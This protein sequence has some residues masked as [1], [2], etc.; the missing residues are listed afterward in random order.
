MTNATKAAIILL[1]NATM[2][3]VI[4][5]GINLTDTQQASI[6]TF[7]NAVLGVWMLATYKNSNKRIPEN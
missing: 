1:I 7:A 3:L 4:A 5:F 2:G 6:T